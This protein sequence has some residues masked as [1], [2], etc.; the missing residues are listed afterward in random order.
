MRVVH[1]RLPVRSYDDAPRQESS[2]HMQQLQRPR[3]RATMRQVVSRRSLNV[4]L[5]PTTST[6]IKNNSRQKP[7]PRSQREKSRKQITKQ[8]KRFFL[9]FSIFELSFF[10]FSVFKLVRYIIVFIVAFYMLW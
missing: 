4:R 1:K 5:S 7:I 2:V 3:R 6:K 8:L 10:L 9:C